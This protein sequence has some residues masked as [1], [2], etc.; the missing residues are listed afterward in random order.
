M[1]EVGNITQVDASYAAGPYEVVPLGLSQFLGVNANA[2]SSGTT[3]P[4]GTQT[5]GSG[6]PLNIVRPV[7]GFRMPHGIRTCFYDTFRAPLAS[8]S[9]GVFT[10]GLA[11]ELLLALDPIQANADTTGLYKAAFDV[12]ITNINTSAGGTTLA[13]T[14]CTPDDSLFITNSATCATTSAVQQT[15]TLPT[16]ILTSALT[17]G[18]YTYPV[19]T[20]VGGFVILVVTILKAATGSSPM[21]NGEWGLIRIRRL[22]DNSS[23]TSPGTMVLV[24]YSI[25]GN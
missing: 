20:Y 25:Y 24:N 14:Y 11:V 7:R 4:T 13:T 3:Y 21:V 22:G 1:A 18:G 10:T 2:A 8:G 5:L 12:A 17:S 16:G 6:P 23:D 19:G 9:G 15:A